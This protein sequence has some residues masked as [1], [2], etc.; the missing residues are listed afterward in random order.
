[1][2]N[3]YVILA[4]EISKEQQNIVTNYFKEQPSIGYWHW[5]KDCWLLT[6]VS[7]LWNVSKLRDKVRELVQGVDIL[8]IRVES[9]NEWAA[10]GKKETFKWLHET[11]KDY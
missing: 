6:D 5:F 1:M 7:D 4:D 3:R 10:F 8:V 2:K 9:G 11:W